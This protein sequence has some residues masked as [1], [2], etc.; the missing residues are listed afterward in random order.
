MKAS[1]EDPRF[2]IAMLLILITAVLDIGTVILLL[3]HPALSSETYGLVTLI[4]GVW[5]AALA[6]A[7]GYW[8]GSSHSSQEKDATIATVAKNGNGHS[9]PA[10]GGQS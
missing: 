3:D 4:L 9:E 8:I 7:Y 6:G 10:Q 1:F 2:L 5:H